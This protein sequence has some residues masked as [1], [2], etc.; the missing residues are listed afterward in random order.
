MPHDAKPSTRERLLQATADLLSEAPGEDVSIRAICERAGVT[1]PTLYH[2]FGS[3]DGLIDTVVR[4][5]FEAYVRH[6][7]EHGQSD[8]PIRDIREGWDGHVAFGLANPSFYAVMYGRVR[9]GQRPTSAR[10][11]EAMLLELTT[12]AQRRGLLRVDPQAAANAILATNI[13]VTL[14]LITMPPETVDPELSPLVREAVLAAVARLPATE[15]PAPEG[16]PVQEHAAALLQVLG[17]DSD[18]LAPQELALLVLWLH[19]LA[20]PNS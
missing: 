5:G 13:G 16:D 17:P 3:K 10:E 12:A 2:F 7:Q 15:A 14:A 20:T 6:K 11:P 4:H 18:R 1:L 8:D 9:P 19:R